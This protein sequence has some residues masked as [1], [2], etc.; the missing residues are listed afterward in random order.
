MRLL[1]IFQEYQ[2]E[3]LWIPLL[4]ERINKRRERHCICKWKQHPFGLRMPSVHLKAGSFSDSSRCFD[5]MM[6][7]SWTFANVC[8]IEYLCPSPAPPFLSSYKK[9]SSSRSLSQMLGEESTREH[10]THPSRPLLV[11]YL[12]PN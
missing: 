11:T 12:L 2:I 5:C 1:F 6:P 4:D 3:W 9:C 10:V 7:A 8:I